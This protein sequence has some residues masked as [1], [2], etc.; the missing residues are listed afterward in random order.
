MPRLSF[1]VDFIA[2]V[3]LLIWYPLSHWLGSLEERHKF[4]VTSPTYEADA[5]EIV[6]E[7]IPLESRPTVEILHCTARHLHSELAQRE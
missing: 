3:L 2:G 6:L 4:E 1:A 7:S 5:D